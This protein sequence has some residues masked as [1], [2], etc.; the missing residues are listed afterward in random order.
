MTQKKSVG[1]KIGAYLKYQREKR[2][3]SLVEFGKLL[4]IDASFLH[5]LEKG[6]YQSVSLDA[7]EK[8]T[9]GLQMNIQE[10]LAKCEITPSRFSL[11]TAEY[12]YKEMYQFPDEAIADIQLFVKFLQEKYKHEIKL[13]KKKHEIY[14]KNRKQ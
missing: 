2:K 14:W 9:N 5:R 10:F 8:I 7:I 1:V 13:N 3:L 6:Y 11:P 4:D 12:F